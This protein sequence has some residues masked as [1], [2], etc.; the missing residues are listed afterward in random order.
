MEV[1]N[2]IRDAV[3]GK[4][5]FDD[6]DLTVRIHKLHK[7]IFTLLPSDYVDRVLYDIY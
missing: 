2:D 5:P 7:H 1:L 3:A 4:R 6:A